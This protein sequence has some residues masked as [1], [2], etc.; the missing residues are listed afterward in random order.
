[1]LAVQYVVCVDVLGLM[2][3]LCTAV[4]SYTSV[5]SSIV[6]LLSI[7]VVRSTNML[8]SVL[9]VVLM[10]WAL[11]CTP[12]SALSALVLCIAS[13]LLAI[14]LL[15]ATH[16]TAV[17][18]M[19]STL[20]NSFFWLAIMAG[21]QHV[22][23]LPAYVVVSTLLVVIVWS[24]SA[25]PRLGLMML[26]LLQLVAKVYLFVGVVL[27][28]PSNS[29][30]DVCTLISVV[31][32]T[33]SMLFC[34]TDVRTM[35]VVL[36]SA[37]IVQVSVLGSTVGMSVSVVLYLLAYVLV[38]IVLLVLLSSARS[39]SE[40]CLLVAVVLCWSGMP[41]VSVAIGKILLVVMV[42]NW[43]S[44][45]LASVLLVVWMLAA[46]RVLLVVLADP[47]SYPIWFLTYT[48]SVG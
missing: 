2:L 43:T 22:D 46:M 11:D 28:C 20:T 6:L 36:S 33:V 7:Y 40:L 45:L 34:A 37:W 8:T 30:L 15:S 14:Q 25:V 4:T 27:L 41:L 12:T 26:V 42:L 21:S 35:C 17:Y 38:S 19:L 3:G 13:I 47:S 10:S 32:L 44:L 24:V 29:V 16:L 18:V 1:V 5:A 48:D 31:T 39:W 23:V 9:G